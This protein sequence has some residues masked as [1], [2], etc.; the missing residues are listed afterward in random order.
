[1]FNFRAPKRPRDDTSDS[2][3]EQ[4]RYATKSRPWAIPKRPSALTSL[5][6]PPSPPRTVPDLELTTRATSEPSDTNSPNS[7]QDSPFPFTS[8]PQLRPD[9][10]SDGDHDMDTEMDMDVDADFDIVS[11]P[12]L[13]PSPI[14]TFAAP[15]RPAKLDASLW[16][17]DNGISSS[18]STRRIPTPMHPTFRL[19]GVGYPSGGMAGGL[20]LHPDPYSHA[21]STH[22]SIP[23]N[24]DIQTANAVSYTEN[25]HLRLPSPIREDEDHDLESHCYTPTTITQSQLSRLSVDE[26]MHLNGVNALLHA[27]VHANANAESVDEAGV[28]KTP[29]PGRKRSGAL[30]TKGKFSMGYRDDCEKCRMRVPGHY[31]HFLP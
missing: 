14:D 2:E 26:G 25:Q 31:A 1:M 10:D 6:L 4:Q 16:G 18:N 22:L 12:S 17:D 3:E 7:F 23:S 11:S 28:N 29:T 21:R 9:I 30:S 24:L 20:N 19:G 13:D 5:H 8:P 27:N 15:L